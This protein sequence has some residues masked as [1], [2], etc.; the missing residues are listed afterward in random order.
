MTTAIQSIGWWIGD[1]DLGRTRWFEEAKPWSSPS[2]KATIQQIAVDLK[3]MVIQEGVA[4]GVYPGLSSYFV[5]PTPAG[6]E[7]CPMLIAR[8][9]GETASTGFRRVLAAGIP[10]RAFVGI[11][12]RFDQPH[13]EVVEPGGCGWIPGLLQVIEGRVVAQAV[14]FAVN[15]S[16]VR[17]AF[18]GQYKAGGGHSDLHEA[19]VV[20]ATD[21]VAPRLA[22]G[23]NPQAHGFGHA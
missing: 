5:A 14:P 18:R 3:P 19:P 12:Q 21:Q 6:V 10:L 8:T 17:A 2:L 15:L 16:V 1:Y 9:A 11:S 22:I 4:I 23:I 13:E 20:G 7:A